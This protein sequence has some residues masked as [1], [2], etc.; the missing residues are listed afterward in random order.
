[1]KRTIL[2]ILF[3]VYVLGSYSQTISEK[4]LKKQIGDLLNSYSFYNRFS[5]NV[6]V[7]RN[8]NVIFE[9][10]YGFADIETKKKNT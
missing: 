9:K 7:T 2:L 1:M 4:E 8:N 6:L 3:S 10:S 5:G